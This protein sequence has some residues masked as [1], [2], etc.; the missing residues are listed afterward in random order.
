MRFSEEALRIVWTLRSQL[1]LGWDQPGRNRTVALFRKEPK[2]FQEVPKGRSSVILRQQSVTLSWFGIWKMQF[3]RDAIR[4]KLNRLAAQHHTGDE[5][6]VQ[7]IEQGEQENEVLE[8]LEQWIARYGE[9]GAVIDAEAVL[10]LGVLIYFRSDGKHEKERLVQ[11]EQILG[12]FFE[13][14]HKKKKSRTNESANPGPASNEIIVDGIQDLHAEVEQTIQSFNAKLDDSLESMDSRVNQRFHA[15]NAELG[16]FVQ[17]LNL[18]MDQVIRS[19]HAK[20]DRNLR[21]LTN[22]VEQSI[23]RLNAEVHHDVQSLNARV[24]QLLTSLEPQT[25]PRPAEVATPVT[26]RRPLRPPLWSSETVLVLSSE[27]VVFPDHSRRSSRHSS[28]SRDRSVEPHQKPVEP[29]E[30]D[31]SQE[32]TEDRPK[33]VK[34]ERESSV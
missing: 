19:L 25:T 32:P 28:P 29:V 8:S 3:T 34:E 1:E 11:V 24:D 30:E 9:E 17:A 18:K 21:S 26:P 10:N 20:V 6:D 22:Y 13:A 15:L 16:N 12:A 33:L 31:A 7:V 2:D 14:Q 4:A 5:D 23:Q 27:E